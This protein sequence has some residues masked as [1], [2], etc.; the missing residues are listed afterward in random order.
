M[1]G[2][3]FVQGHS[4]LQL[5]I[6]RAPN[7]PEIWTTI[8]NLFYAIRQPVDSLD[9]FRRSIRLNSYVWIN[10]HNLGVLVRTRSSCST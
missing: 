3:K 9:G 5:A 10:W 2:G 7:I 4:C 1:A 8:G 6:Y